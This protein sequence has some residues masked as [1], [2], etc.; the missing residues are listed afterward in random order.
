LGTSKDTAAYS[1]SHGGEQVVLV[2]VAEL[3]GVGL[4]A[5]GQGVQGDATVGGLGP[6]HHAGRLGELGQ[7]SGEL[8]LGATGG[9]AAD[10]DH[11][12]VGI[13][14]VD[15]AGEGE[16]GEPLLAGIGHP[17]RHV[18]LDLLGER[19]AVEEHPVLLEDLADVDEAGGV[20]LGR[21]HGGGFGG[22]GKGRG[23]ESRSRHIGRE[24]LR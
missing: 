21:N 11:E 8:G 7:A 2:G 17:H 10:V 15:G 5:L 3:D 22:L 9:G 14:A 6:L 18:L 4:L 16:L 12:L 20:G 1:S 13:E 19:A 23:N 24:S